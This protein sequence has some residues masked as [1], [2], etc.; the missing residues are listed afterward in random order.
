[1]FQAHAL[2][3]Q[4]GVVV[5]SNLVADPAVR[6]NLARSSL[7][8]VGGAL[9]LLQARLLSSHRVRTR[10]KAFTCAFARACT[11]FPATSMR[12]CRSP[13]R[14]LQRCRKASVL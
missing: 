6:Y 14:V 8:F 13:S 5:L 2:S 3:A 10:S 7:A 1:M 9:P 11:A 12:V 4:V